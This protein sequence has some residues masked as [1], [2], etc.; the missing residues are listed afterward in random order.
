MARI[1]IFG[2]GYVGVVAAACLAKDG[3]D[4]IAVDVDPGKVD[5]INNAKSPIVEKGL[6]DLVKE[7]VEAGRL[8]ATDDVQH[9]IDNTDDIRLVAGHWQSRPGGRDGRRRRQTV[10]VGVDRGWVTPKVDVD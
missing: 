7:V 8:I 10:D 4:V 3:H 6:G 9:A 2:I 5:A 1:S